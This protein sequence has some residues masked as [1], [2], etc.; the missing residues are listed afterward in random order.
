MELIV[1]T[2]I[3]CQIG[4]DKPGMRIVKVYED[5]ITHE[6]HELEHFPAHAEL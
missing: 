2:A 3:G 5:K 6:F 4:D 1:T